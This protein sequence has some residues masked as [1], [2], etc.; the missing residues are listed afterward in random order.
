MPRINSNKVYIVFDGT[1]H[2]PIYGCDFDPN[3]EEIVRGPFNDLNDEVDALTER[4]ND[5]AY[6]TQMYR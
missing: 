5:E 6:G 4:L 1:S 3:E 2:Y